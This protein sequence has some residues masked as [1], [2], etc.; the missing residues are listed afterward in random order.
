VLIGFIAV[1]VDLEKEGVIGPSVLHA[2][3]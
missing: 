1:Q 3:K 2:S